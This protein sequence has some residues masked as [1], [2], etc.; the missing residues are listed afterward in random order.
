V[1]FSS[2]AGA[3][4]TPDIRVPSL[5]ST[6]SPPFV[7]LDY[8]I[9]ADGQTSEEIGTYYGHPPNRHGVGAA[10]S[11]T[12]AAPTL[13]RVNIARGAGATIARG[14]E[15]I[16]TTGWCISEGAHSANQP[17]DLML[18]KHPNAPQLD[19]AC[20]EGLVSMFKRSCNCETMPH[21]IGAVG[22]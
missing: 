12:I 15:R 20:G 16:L 3:L 9:H 5:C 21:G 10:Y 8:C 4:F 19:D 22:H 1:Q 7:K 2:V 18:L 14:S 13:T 6:Q 11:L 17:Q